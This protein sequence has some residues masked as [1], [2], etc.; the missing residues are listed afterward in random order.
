VRQPD[1]TGISERERKRRALQRA[2]SERR[3][4][5]IAEFCDRFGIGRTFAYEQIKKHRLR[6]RKAGRRTIV[7]DED[8]ERWLAS[9]PSS[10]APEAM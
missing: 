8:A 5:S 1:N 4:Y 3:A 2:E 6:V 7:T 10:D 9:L